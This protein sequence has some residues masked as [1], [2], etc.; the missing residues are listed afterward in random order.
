MARKFG[1][2]GRNELE[3]AEMEMYTHYI[4]LILVRNRFL[5]ILKIQK[6]YGDQI[7]DMQSEIVKAFCEKDEFK[8]IDLVRNL[9]AQKLPRHFIIFETKLNESQSGYF[10]ESGLTWV[11]LYLFHVLEKLGA[12]KTEAFENFE[13]LKAHDKRIRELPKIAEWLAKRPKTN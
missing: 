13:T 5:T 10:S 9:I 12:K 1:I 11:D 6:R 8:R 2:A 4:F 3:Q 7:T